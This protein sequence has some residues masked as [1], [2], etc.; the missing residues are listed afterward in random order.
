MND[1]EFLKKEA[2]SIAEERESYFIACIIMF[3]II[4]MLTYKVAY[5]QRVINKIKS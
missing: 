4:T 5:L 2:L 1:I 3:C